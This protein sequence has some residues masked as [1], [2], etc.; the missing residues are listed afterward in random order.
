MKKH[1]LFALKNAKNNRWIKIGVEGEWEGHENGKF[2]LN[3]QIFNQMVENFQNG[4]VDLVVDYEHATLYEPKAP[5][6]GWITREPFNLKVKD[7]TL[8]IRVDWTD[9]A[10][11]HIEAKEYR[12]LSPVF[13]FD[14]KD[15]TTGNSIGAILHSV[16]LTNTPFLEE[17]GAIA[18]KQTKE[19][20]MGK[21]TQEQL[22]EANNKLANKDVKIQELEAKIL[23]LEKG[24]EDQKALSAKSKVATALSTGKI[25]KGQEAWAL[26]YATADAEGFDKFVEHAQV[27]QGF[28]GEQF[29]NSSTKKGEEE[30][31]IGMGKV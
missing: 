3:T 31:S 2:T 10:K 23:D 17:L 9:E 18:N 22:K 7:K 4:S 16:A 13:I 14:A 5:A 27:P 12:Y 19:K 20:A 24:I 1:K 21:T 29:A 15:K 28:G 6:G 26:S 25:S 11:K 30:A 8:W